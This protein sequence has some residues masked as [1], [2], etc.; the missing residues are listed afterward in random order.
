M[1]DSW[2]FVVPYPTSEFFPVC[3]GGGFQLFF[4]QSHYCGIGKGHHRSRSLCGQVT[5]FM[6]NVYLLIE[7][8]G[9]VGG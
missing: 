4:L 7:F 8:M 2:A 5:A 9:V 3:I 6:S 1:F